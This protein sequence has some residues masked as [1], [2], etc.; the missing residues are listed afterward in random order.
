MEP[1]GKSVKIGIVGEKAFLLVTRLYSVGGRNNGSYQKGFVDVYSTANWITNFQ[2]FFLPNKNVRKKALTESSHNLTGAKTIPSV[3]AY[4]R[5]LFVLD[6]MILILINILFS[7]R[8]ASTTHPRVR[9][10]M[11]SS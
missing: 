3:R 1:I 11:P 8:S 6:K 9:C 10:S 7:T 4:M 2:I 5:H